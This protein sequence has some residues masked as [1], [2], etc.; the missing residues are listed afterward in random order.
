M[1]SENVIGAD[2]EAMCRLLE[3]QG[4]PYQRFDHPAV[5]TCEQAERMV[6]AEADAVHTKNLFLRDKKGRRHFLVTVPY[7]KAVDIDAL[8]DEIGVNGL[9]FGSEERLLRHLGIKPGSVSL[10]ALANDEARA[11]E[12]V[13]DKALWDA[14]AV[15][16]HPLNFVGFGGFGFGL[17]G[18]VDRFQLS[19]AFR[20]VGHHANPQFAPRGPY[21]HRRLLP[22][23][24]TC[25][26]PVCTPTPSRKSSRST[27][28]HRSRTAGSASTIRS[29][30]RHASS[31]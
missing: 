20:V 2:P 27:P 21:F 18:E 5:F 25:A 26:M 13:L 15:H 23:L 29:A 6:P 28:A 24:P 9:G 3:T 16:A 1:T 8:A 7:D 19:D 17:V 11:V 30:A 10:L 22:A 31:G 12:F 14:E 4:I